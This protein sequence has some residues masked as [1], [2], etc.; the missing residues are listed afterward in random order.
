MADPTIETRHEGG[1]EQ[2]EEHAGPA[3][4]EAPRGARAAAAMRDSL[5]GGV[6]G[7][8]TV[9]SEGVHMVR[10]IASDTLR[11]AGDVGSVAVDTTRHL[12]VDVADGVRDIL[13][14]IIPFRTGRGEGPGER[15]EH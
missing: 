14:H 10:D 1:K 4:E 5:I 8:Q 15:K 6:H 3:A 9:M 7:A 12:L 11:A 2:M 13:T